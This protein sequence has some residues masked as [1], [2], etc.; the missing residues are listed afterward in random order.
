MLRR[1][2]PQRRPSPP[3]Q[4]PQWLRLAQLPSLPL[5]RATGR[6]GYRPACRVPRM[7]LHFPARVCPRLRSPSGAAGPARF[8]G[9][10]LNIMLGIMRSAKTRCPA[11]AR[12]ICIMCK[13]PPLVFDSP[14]ALRVA[15]RGFSRCA[16]SAPRARAARPVR[17]EG[18]PLRRVA[19]AGLLRPRLSTCR[20]NP[21]TPASSC[22]VP[23]CVRH[24]CRRR[25]Y[26][27]VRRVPVGVLWRLDSILVR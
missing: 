19:L 9:R 15:A 24:S 20:D 10:Q 23:A 6:L 2:R 11:R 8:G 26:R 25:V 4:C 5:A 21:P 27:H 17:P 14:P 1:L 22:G 16:S 13:L 18:A 7:A 12:I 3:A